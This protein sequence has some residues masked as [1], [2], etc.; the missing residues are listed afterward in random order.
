MLTRYVVVCWVPGPTASSAMAYPV[1][2]FLAASE[3]RRM[4]ISNSGGYPSPPELLS[5]CVPVCWLIRQCSRDNS[6]STASQSVMHTPPSS[7]AMRA[8]WSRSPARN[9]LIS[10]APGKS[11]LP[12]CRLLPF[13]RSSDAHP[14]ASLPVLRWCGEEEFDSVQGPGCPVRRSRSCRLRPRQ[15]GAAAARPVTLTPLPPTPGLGA[16]GSPAT[17]RGRDRATAAGIR[18]RPWTW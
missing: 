14:Q 12:P 4:R 11:A 1:G 15:L 2:G 18:R 16:T 9:P 17:V 6:A 5:C 7:S 10:I 13:R 8:S 3:W